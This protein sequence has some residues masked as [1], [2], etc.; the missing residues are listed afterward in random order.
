MVSMYFWFQ[1]YT[2]TIWLVLWLFLFFLSLPLFLWYRT[3]MCTLT[4]EAYLA[5]PMF[6]LFLT[7][8]LWY[9]FITKCSTTILSLTA[10]LVDTLT[11][12]KTVAELLYSLVRSLYK[13]QFYCFFLSLWTQLDLSTWSSIVLSRHLGNILDLERLDSSLGLPTSCCLCGHPLKS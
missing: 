1:A 2:Y 11:S 3:I 9:L 13:I 7:T 8:L 12:I 6:L 4:H 10:C 5:F